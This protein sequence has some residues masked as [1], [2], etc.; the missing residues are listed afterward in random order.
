MWR[1]RDSNIHMYLH[2]SYLIAQ[3]I[4]NA[5]ASAARHKSSS[6]AASA[7]ASSSAVAAAASSSSSFP[8]RKRSRPVPSDA[9]DGVELPL[10]TLDAPGLPPIVT[11]KWL[12]E[13]VRRSVAAMQ[14]A[15]NQQQQQG[16]KDKGKGKR[17]APVVVRIALPS[18][19][20]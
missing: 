5:S 14:K 12:E 10:E 16:A 11:H 2:L 19:A 3:I 20:E 18:L 7:S 17:A 4:N 13:F 8:S 1:I 9:G 6:G 15:L